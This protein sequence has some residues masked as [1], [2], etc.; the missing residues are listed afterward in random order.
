MKATIKWGIL[1]AGNIA[2]S[3]VKGLKSLPDAAVVAVAA[4]SKDKAEAFAMAY[5]IPRFY[6]SYIELANDP[7]IDII[8]VSTLHPFHRDCTLLCLK[9]GKAVICEKPFTINAIEAQELISYAREQKLFLTDA[10]WTRYLPANIKVMQLL[11]DKVIGDVKMVKA[12]FGF[13]CGWNPQSR[14]LN[15]ELGGGAL[16]DVG[17]YTIAYASMAFNAAKPLKIVSMPRIGETG[18]DEEFS[19]IIG[20]EGGGLAMLTGAVRTKTPQEAWILGTKGRIHIP[21]FWHAQSATLYLDGEKEQAFE[22]PYESTGYNY[23]AAY[24]MQCLREKRLESDIMPLDESLQIMKTMDEIRA[25][26][27]L[28]YPFE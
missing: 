23:E 1:G 15:P 13:R 6:G 12:D 20:Y 25:Q 4:R 16:L 28:K 7:D 22:L 3:F 2:N 8:Y 27:G 26:W 21:S 9:A 5:E 18:I 11:S 10:M 19:A 14:L 17:V 24:A